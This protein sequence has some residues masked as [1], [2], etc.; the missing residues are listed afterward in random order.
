MIMNAIAKPVSVFDVYERAKSGPEMSEADWDFGVIPKTAKKLKEKYKIKMDKKVIIPEDKTLIDNLFKAG[1][2]MLEECG[3]YCIDTN[4]VIKY[5]RD[6]I[7]L[8]IK[9]APRHFTFG[10]DQE[11]I[12]VTPRAY[13][14]KTP[15]VIQGGPTGSPCSEAMFLPI[16]QSYAQEPIVDTI[17][18]GVLQTVMGKDPVPSSPWEIMAV[19][20]ELFQVREAMSRAGRSGMGL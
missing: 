18:N 5:T 3:V 20:S 15:P 1:L 6:E 12:H 13:N 10:E 14:S 11:A 19:R 2:D 17:V 16:H 9:N 4:R 8:A 7:L